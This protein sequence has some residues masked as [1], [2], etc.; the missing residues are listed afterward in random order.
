MSVR[1]TVLSAID[2]YHML[3]GASALLIAL[4]GGSD[5]VALLRI[6]SDICAEK[7]IKLYAAHVN[8]LIRGGEAYRDQDFCVK[9][10]REMDIP[11]FIG[12]FDVPRA[13]K[14][15]NLSL[16]TAARDIRYAYFESLLDL[17]GIDLCATAHNARD[18]AETVIFNI[19]RGASLSGASGIPPLR[20]RYIRPLIDCGK[21]EIIDYNLSLGQKWMEDSTNADTGYTRNF[22][23]S[24]IIPRIERIQPKAVEAVCR[25]ADSVS[26]DESFIRGIAGEYPPDTGISALSRMHDAILYR[27]LADRFDEAGCSEYGDV[28]IKDAAGLIRKGIKGSMLSL[29]GGVRMTVG[30]TVAFGRDPRRKAESSGYSYGIEDSKPL[31]IPEAGRIIIIGKDMTGCSGKIEYDQNIYKLSIQ[32]PLSSDKIKGGVKVTSRY[33]GDRIR[34]LGID[35]SLSRLMNICHMERVIRGQTP[36]IRDENGIICIPELILNGK[37]VCRDD[38]FLSENDCTDTIFVLLYSPEKEKIYRK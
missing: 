16:E 21:P 20:G 6:M 7:N 19:A 38:V 14:E 3:D 18:R 25:F 22:I 15:K 30:N 24:E 4:S 34:C 32:I 2:R 5:S 26:R 28:H 12:I 37:P 31:F 23:R 29:P 11:L 13:A 36:V 17:Y 8:H 33:D 1:D 27:W 9:L 10:C 35:R